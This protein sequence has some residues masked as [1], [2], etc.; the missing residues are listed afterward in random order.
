MNFG[1]IYI[2]FKISSRVNKFKFEITESSKRFK[3]FN[4][5]YNKNTSLDFGQNLRAT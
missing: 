2:Y 3:I 5:F 1:I 4:Y